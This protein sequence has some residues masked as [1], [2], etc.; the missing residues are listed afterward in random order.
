MDSLNL[1]KGKLAL[2]VNAQRFEELQLAF[3]KTIERAKQALTLEE[4]IE[5]T[6]RLQQITR[7]QK[8]LFTGFGESSLGDG[9][10]ASRKRK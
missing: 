1:K 5:L 2:G 6:E 3:R 8:E 4:R 10:K 9:I 7:E